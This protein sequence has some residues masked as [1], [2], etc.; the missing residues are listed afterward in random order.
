MVG[1]AANSTDPKTIMIDATYLKAHRP[2]CSLREKR[3]WP[4]DRLNKRRHEHEAARCHR[5]DRKTFSVLPVGITGQRLYRRCDAHKQSAEGRVK[6]RLG[7]RYDTESAAGRSTEGDAGSRHLATA[8]LPPGRSRS[9]DGASRAAARQSGDA[10]G[11]GCASPVWLSADRT[12]VERRSMLINPK[13][14]Y[15]LYREEGLSVRRRRGR[16]RARGTRMPM[17]PDPHT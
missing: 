8:G 13:K 2:A 7:K 4:P 16:K 17:P 15:R 9:E 3:G 14:L 5:C 1:L 10:G 6:D 12:T 11:R